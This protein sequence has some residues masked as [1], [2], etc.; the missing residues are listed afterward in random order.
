MDI[1]ADLLEGLIKDINFDNYYNEATFQ[2]KLLL[3]L[4][5]IYDE[6]KILPERRS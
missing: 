4:S 1:T 3:K 6:S 2:F 5:E